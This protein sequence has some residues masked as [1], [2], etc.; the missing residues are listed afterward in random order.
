MNPIRLT[1]RQTKILEAL[2]DESSSDLI[3]FVLYNHGHQT[4][5][6]WLEFTMVNGGLEQSS[7]LYDCQIHEIITAIKLNFNVKESA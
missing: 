1:E 5:M 4:I 6:E 2:G 3:A 7:I